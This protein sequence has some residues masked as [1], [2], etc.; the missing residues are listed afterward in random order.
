MPSCTATVHVPS[1]FCSPSCLYPT[2][3]TRSFLQKLNY[4]YAQLHGDSLVTAADK[5]LG[6]F[7]ARALKA[8]RECWCEWCGGAGVIGAEISVILMIGSGRWFG[9]RGRLLCTRARGPA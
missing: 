8:L 9:W 2:L 7:F 1:A 4:R 5:E 3:F 6:G